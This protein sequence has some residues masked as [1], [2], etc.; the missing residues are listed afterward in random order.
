MV[1]N[2]HL[3]YRKNKNDQFWLKFIRLSGVDMN[4][5]EYSAFECKGYA[6]VLNIACSNNPDNSEGMLI[7]E[8]NNLELQ[9]EVI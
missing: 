7:E 3:I 9:Q 5:N 8:W 4:G 1:I 6:S 2:P